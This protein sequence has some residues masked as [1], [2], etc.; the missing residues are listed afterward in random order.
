MNRSGLKKV[1]K[2]V[3]GRKGSVRRSYWV[4]SSQDV[5]KKPGF[6]AR[7][8][9]K[10][11]RVAGKVA[12][13]GAGVGAAYLAHKHIKQKLDA[14]KAPPILHN[15]HAQ[16]PFHGITRNTTAE[17]HAYERN[18]KA[19]LKDHE[20]GKDDV[21][22]YMLEKVRREAPPMHNGVRASTHEEVKAHRDALK[23]R[24]RRDAEARTTAK[25]KQRL[26]KSGGR[27]F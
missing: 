20:R 8:G 19:N 21:T 3:K 6:L 12:L 11:L 25:M 27:R 4:K 14:R 2:M 24:S 16:N 1:T 26:L 17:F 22:R 9:K 7:H 23:E 5:Q 10:I 15:P 18:R 13:A